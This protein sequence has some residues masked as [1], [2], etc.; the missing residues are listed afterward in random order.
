MS[1]DFRNK[2]RFESRFECGNLSMAFER[3]SQSYILL[4]QNDINTYGCTQWFYFRVENGKTTGKMEFEIANF[5]KSSSLF[6]LGMKVL[7]YSSKKRH[8]EGSK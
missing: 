2:I 8:G 1:K 7:V 6:T 4:M 5:H 3:N